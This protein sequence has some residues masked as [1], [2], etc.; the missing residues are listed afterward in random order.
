[1]SSRSLC[2][3]IRCS[4]IA[5]AVCTIILCAVWYPASFSL[6]N[7]GFIPAISLKLNAAQIWSML[8]FLWLCSL[9]CF[10]ILIIF[11]KISTAIKKEE[12]FTMSSAKRIKLCAV[13]F[14]IDLAVFFIGNLI[15]L[16]LG[17]NG[18]AFFHFALFVGGAVLGIFA[19][20]L[21]HYV[22][23]AAELQEENEGTI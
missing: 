3:W 8:A 23:K 9:P 11:W 4:I 18:F 16:L 7:V 20:A 21:S 2:F 17:I 14:F 22:A 15:F 13:V 12:L 1:M 10:F 19:S 6:I 5:I